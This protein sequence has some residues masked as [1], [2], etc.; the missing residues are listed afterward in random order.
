MSI[1]NLE[2]YSP[3][4]VT[5]NGIPHSIWLR[6]HNDP[7][8]DFIIPWNLSRVIDEKLPLREYPLTQEQ[9]DELIAQGYEFIPLDPY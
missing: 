7:K 6:A 8:K 1:A 4:W 3:E 5:K 9:Y 2:P